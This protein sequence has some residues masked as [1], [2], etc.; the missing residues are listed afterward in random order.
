M[1]YLADDL[2]RTLC[3]T[4]MHDEAS[5]WFMKT[6]VDH[7]AMG[8]LMPYPVEGPAFLADKPHALNGRT[9]HLGTSGGA[10]AAR[11]QGDIHDISW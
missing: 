11:R 3:S 5:L 2:P 4:T 8:T 10:C 6:L 7:D 1:A 9:V